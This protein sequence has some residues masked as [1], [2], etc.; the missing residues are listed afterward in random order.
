[1]RGAVALVLDNERPGKRRRDLGLSVRVARRCRMIPFSR[2]TANTPASARRGD[3]STARALALGP[4]E[5]S[6]GTKRIDRDRRLSRLA[7]PWPRRNDGPPARIFLLSAAARFQ[8]PIALAMVRLMK[9]FSNATF[10]PEVIRAMAVAL[11][12]AVATLPEPV[13]ST[14][15]NIL[16]ESILR[17]AKGGQ[18]DPVVLQRIAL[19]E[20]NLTRH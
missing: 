9:D 12:S 3:V 13:S 19:L 5:F 10:S 14:H 16:A 1:M 2:L 7:R 11:E 20:L 17:T 4:R 15:V 18:T 6:P 8:E